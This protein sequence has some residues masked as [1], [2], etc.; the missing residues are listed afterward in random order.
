M[1]TYSHNCA[2]IRLS[3]AQV[4]IGDNIF[5]EVDIGSVESVLKELKTGGTSVISRGLMDSNKVY[6]Q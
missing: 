4:D 3:T 5:V 1:S 6:L 2:Y